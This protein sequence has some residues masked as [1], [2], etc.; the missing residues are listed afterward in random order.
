[1]NYALQRVD[2]IEYILETQDLDLSDTPHVR[3]HKSVV[4]TDKASQSHT[5]KYP[6]CNGLKKKNK[7]SSILVSQGGVLV[8]R[9]ELPHCGPRPALPPFVH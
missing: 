7:R 6:S 4:H 2:E 5:P 1:M 8:W 9:P 3:D